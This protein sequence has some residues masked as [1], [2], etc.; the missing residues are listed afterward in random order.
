MRRCGSISGEEPF[1]RGNLDAGRLSWLFGARSSRP[2]TPSIP[3]ATTRLLAID[4]D[5][6]RSLLT[7]RLSRNDR[8]CRAPASGPLPG[9]SL[10]QSRGFAQVRKSRLAAQGPR[11]IP[12]ANRGS[13]RSE[14]INVDLLSDSVASW[15]SPA[16]SPGAAPLTASAPPR[17]PRDRGPL[18]A[19]T[20]ADV[21][22]SGALRRGRRR[23]VLLVAPGAPNCY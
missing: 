9:V 1:V 4:A 11:W 2:R 23:R 15:P 18:A 7:L 8:G 5:R 6:A 12:F 22:D 20:E 14:K 17:A 10:R 21:S 16:S 3:K 13:D 19:A